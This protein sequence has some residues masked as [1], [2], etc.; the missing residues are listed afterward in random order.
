MK[1]K[2]SCKKTRYRVQIA[3]PSALALTLRDLYKMSLLTAKHRLGVTSIKVL[4]VTL[5]NHL[6]GSDHVRDVICRCGQSLY[7][8]KVLRCHGMKEEELRLIYKSVVLAKLMYASPAWWVCMLQPQIRSA[9]KHLFD[10]E[11][12]LVSIMPTI[13]RRRNW[14]STATTNSSAAY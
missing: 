12:G 3:L 1:M 4:G 11:C 10:E 13:Q 2:L 7:A 6:S 9:L 5:T 8:I 14:P